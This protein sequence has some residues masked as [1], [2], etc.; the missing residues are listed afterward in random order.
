MS[1]VRSVEPESSTCTSSLHAQVARQSAM[2][3]SS[4]S[5]RMMIVTGSFCCGHV[6]LGLSRCQNPIKLCVIFYMQTASASKPRNCNRGAFHFGPISSRGSPA[7]QHRALEVVYDFG[8][9]QRPPRVILQRLIQLK[10]LLA[11]Q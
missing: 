9:V 4:L 10:P 6:I 2:F 5:V 11:H 7:E 3:G 1:H 8:S